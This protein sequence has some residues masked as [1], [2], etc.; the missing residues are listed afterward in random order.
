MKM[1]LIETKTSGINGTM[2]W[3]HYFLRAYTDAMHDA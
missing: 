1:F 3:T 2:R